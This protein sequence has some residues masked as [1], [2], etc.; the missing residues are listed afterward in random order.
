M[1]DL[2]HNK[3]LTVINLMGGPGCGKSATAYF[4]AGYMK[5]RGM[6][7]EYVP[8]YAKG[9]VWDNMWDE[10]GGVFTEQDFITA[11]QHRLIRRLVNHDIDYVILDTSLLLGLIYAPSW[12]PASYKTFLLDLYHSYNNVVVY[13]DRGSIPYVEDGRN[14]SAE[15]AKE[16]D[17]ESLHVL[18][19]YGIPYH[20]LIQDEVVGGSAS[21]ILNILTQMEEGDRDEASRNITYVDERKLQR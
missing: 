13:L 9:C 15:Q 16:K 4:L 7:V 5:V 17:N 12:Y 19:E 20:Y 6:K 21:K 8:E 10:D 11:N 1:K 14:Q 3:K 2:I 18:D